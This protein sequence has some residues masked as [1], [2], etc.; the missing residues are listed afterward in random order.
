MI[1]RFFFL[2]LKKGY[3]SVSLDG[4]NNSCVLVQNHMKVICIFPN[5]RVIK[6][7]KSEPQG[8]KLDFSLD[9]ITLSFKTNFIMRS[10]L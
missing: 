1:R 6:C 4:K 5:V 9:N 10:V 7:I 3:I 8:G 2:T